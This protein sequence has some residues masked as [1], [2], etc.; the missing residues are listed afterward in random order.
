[1]AAAF[2]LDRVGR[3]HPLEQPPKP[4]APGLS[5]PAGQEEAREQ[6]APQEAP[7]GGGRSGAVGA[8]KEEMGGTQRRDPEQDEDDPVEAVLEPERQHVDDSYSR[9]EEAH[10]GI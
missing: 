5:G 6:E 1:M 7:G 2:H 3:R 8:P 10:E 9:E 4:L